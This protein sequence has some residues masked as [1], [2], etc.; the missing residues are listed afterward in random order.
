MLTV[1]PFAGL[2]NR[3]RALDSVMAIAAHDNRKVKLIWNKN[4]ECNCS[5]T[6]LFTIPENVELK[7][8]ATRFQDNGRVDKTKRK[9]FKL[10]GITIPTGY[11]KVMYD[12]HIIEAKNSGFDWKEILQYK[13]VWFNSTT[14]FYGNGKPF[15][16]LKPSKEIESR[17]A[18]ITANFDDNCIG[19]HIRRSDNIKAIQMSPTQLFIDKI[20]EE[21]AKN[22]KTKVFLATDSPEEEQKLKGIFGERIITTTKVLDRNNPEG[23]K[24]ALIDM[25]CLSHTRFIYGSYWSSFSE[26]AAEF[27]GIDLKILTTETK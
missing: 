2:A 18:S 17:I 23:I 5:F 19:V 3:L 15:S 14:R 25:L 6:D 12:H 22:E 24:G 11:Q 7:E 20:N 16:Y 4:I 10:I 21:I 9:I 13:S 26:T 8:I 1:K 27:G